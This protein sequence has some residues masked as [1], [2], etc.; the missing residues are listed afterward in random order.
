MVVVALVIAIKSRV[1]NIPQ[2]S[3]RVQLG[4]AI[5]NTAF[6]MFAIISLT[7]LFS[8]NSQGVYVLQAAGA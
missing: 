4:Y 6:I 2:Y 5:Y 8:D 7:L 1:I 3:E